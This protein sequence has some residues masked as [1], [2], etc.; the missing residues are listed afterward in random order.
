MNCFTEELIDLLI[1]SPDVR[2]VNSG[3]FSVSMLQLIPYMV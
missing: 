1:T 2:I 3:E